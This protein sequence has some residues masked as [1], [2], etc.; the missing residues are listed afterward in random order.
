MTVGNTNTPLPK[1][2]IC[3]RRTR[4][5]FPQEFLLIPQCRGVHTLHTLT[6]WKNLFYKNQGGSSE[7]QLSIFLVS[8][9]MLRPVKWRSSL[10]QYFNFI[11]KLQ[12]KHLNCRQICVTYFI[13]R[14]CPFWLDQVGK[15]FMIG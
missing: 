14:A 4:H 9:T 7:I 2:L 11:N 3:R 10:R 6:C 1:V 13:R 5:H 8:L 12:T 15:N